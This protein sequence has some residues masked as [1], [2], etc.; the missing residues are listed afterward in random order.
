MPNSMLSTSPQTAAYGNNVTLT[1]NSN[2]DVEG[3]NEAEMGVL[4]MHNGMTLNTT[5]N[6]GVRFTSTSLD[7]GATNTFNIN[8]MSFA[9]GTLNDGGVAMTL[10]KTGTGSMV[11]NQTANSLTK[12]TFQVSAWKTDDRQHGQRLGRP[13]RRRGLPHGHPGHLWQP[14]T[15]F[16]RHKPLD[17]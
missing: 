16:H 15:G 1:A 4:T 3:P 13:G 7:S 6:G 9:P 14:A 10:Y 2:I 8:G 11:L 12:S 5:G 17:L